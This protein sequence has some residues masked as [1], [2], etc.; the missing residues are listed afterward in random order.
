[1]EMKATLIRTTVIM[2]LAFALAA[3]AGASLKEGW[4]LS[5]G[6]A[7]MKI[8]NYKAAIE[9]FE[10]LVAL[11]PDHQEGMRLLG[12]AYERQGLTDKAIGHYDRYLKRFP[13]DFEVAFK[14]ARYL[15]AQ[16][17]GYRREDAIKYYRLGLK[18][19]DDAAMRYR[20]ARLLSADKKHL[21]DAVATFEKLLAGDPDNAR[22]KKEY[23]ELLVWDDRFLEK[24]IA[25][26]EAAVREAPADDALARQLAELY[27]KS[28]RVR[29]RQDAVDSYADLASR[30]PGENTLR[31]RY[32]QALSRI[33]SYTNLASEQFQRALEQKDR[34]GTRLLYADH[35]ARR[36][37]TREAAL[38]NYRQVIAK[39]PDDLSVRFKY[40]RLLGAQ[41]TAAPQA[42][43][44]YQE[45]LRRDPKN[46]AAHRE[47]G[48]AYAW[49]G[50]NDRAIHHANLALRYDR[51]DKTARRLRGDLM[52]G[53]EPR[54]WSGLGYIHQGGDDDHYRYDGYRIFVAG[55][56]DVIPFL[57]AGVEAGRE[58]YD[59]DSDDPPDDAEANVYQIALQYRIDPERWVDGRLRYYDFEDAGND[60]AV[61]MQYTFPKGGWWVGPG[62]RRQLRYDSLLALREVED[63]LSDDKL[64][65]A[66]ANTAFCELRYEGERLEFSVTPYAGVVTA[67]G[68]DDNLVGGADLDT[69]LTLLE[70][71]G[72]Q[73]GAAYRLELSHYDEDQS[74]FTA[75]D[76]VP[77]GGYYSPDFYMNNTLGLDLI[78]E[79]DPVAERELRLSGGPSFQYSQDHD[80]DGGWD[81]GG[82]L[83][84]SFQTRVAPHIQLQV[85]G[86]YHQVADLYQ[87]A[88]GSVQAAYHFR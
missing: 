22:Y 5:R 48:R 21:T 58:H 84:A 10:K 50:D 11:N 1:M 63:A 74:G 24:A 85:E 78:F 61:Q 34:T 17:Y 80:G 42:I 4:Y 62:L 57:T 87:N 88:G 83:Q 51:E 67:E 65:G 53:R 15:E 9:A 38:A 33:D 29:H 43:A 52:E 35:L 72:F 28:P 26:H 79:L 77:A 6:K 23:R 13:K 18:Q 66:R 27:F 75:A 36:P 12:T 2:L 32:A 44:A 69:S 46:S 47:L 30:H 49:E 20:L 54:V 14:Q 3:P 45:I 56:M 86:H 59:G 16:R 19:R 37:A 8:H 60:A 55:Q 71:G 41:K 68:T 25:A 39:R 76:D 81:T 31:V 70:S 82:A 73:L 64:G 40:A 7:N